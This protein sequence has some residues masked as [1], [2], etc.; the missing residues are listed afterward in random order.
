M[1]LFGRMFGRV[2][3]IWMW[4]RELGTIVRNFGVHTEGEYDA[5]MLKADEQLVGI[6]DDMVQISDDESDDEEEGV[7]F[8]SE[9]EDQEAG[10][11]DAAFVVM[12]TGSPG[13]GDR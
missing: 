10:L 3:E 2:R 4:D 5:T 8:S 1:V 13:M 6:P 12:G 9:E 7:E 11:A